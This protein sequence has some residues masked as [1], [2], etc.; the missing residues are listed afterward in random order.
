MSII[1]N[2]IQDCIENEVMTLRDIKS[3][4]GKLVDI[5]CLH[6]K[7]KFY[8]GSLIIDASNNGTDLSAKVSLSEWSRRDLQWWLIALLVN[9]GGK[10]PN[11]DLKY[12]PNT[13]K[14]YT[15]AAGGSRVFPG[16]GIGAVIFP[17]IWCQVLH[18]RATNKGFIDIDG[19]SLPT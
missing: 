1:L 16:R 3:L 18:R 14:I 15:D 7:F 11:P 10:I 4:V 6:Y 8:L 19:R 2:Q 13:L 12:R 5:R 9:N 17:S